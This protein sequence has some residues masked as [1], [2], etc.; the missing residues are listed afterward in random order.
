MK[1]Y[2]NNLWIL[3]DY[4]KDCRFMEI[5]F[6]DIAKTIQMGMET[7]AKKVANSKSRD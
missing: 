6:H 1:N 3:S 5:D 4:F 7:S 2:I